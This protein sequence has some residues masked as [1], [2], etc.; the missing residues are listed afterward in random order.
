MD[1]EREVHR[2]R[3]EA[4]VDQPLG[5]V[6]R[7]EAVGEPVIREQGLVHARPRIPERRLECLVEAA[8][9]VVGVEHGILRHLPQPI[10]A[11]AE[12]VGQR[13][14]EHAHLAME[15]DHPAERAGVMLA[16]G[17][18]FD[19]V[20]AV[21]GLLDERQR[22]EGAERLREHHWPRTRPAAA[23][24][25]REGLVQVDVHRIDA[26]IARTHAPDDRVEIGAVA[27]DEPA[28]R[29]HRVR[30]HAHVALEQ[31]ASVGVGDHHAR[32][33]G[34]ES[35][36][37][38]LG[39]D[40]AV[41]G[42]GYVLDAIARERRG[43]RIG[44]V[45]ALGDEDDFP[46]PLATRFERRADREHAAQLAMRARLRAHRDRVHAG[47][48]D[49]PVRELLDHLERALHALHRR[50][51]VD[52]GETG[53]PRHLLVEARIVLHRARAEREEAEVD[54]VILA[55]QAGIVADGLGL[56]QTRK[57]DRRGTGE[58]AQPR[59]GG[60]GFDKVDAGGRRIADLEDQRFLQHQRL[61]AGG[62]GRSLTARD[63]RFG[64]PSACVDAHAS[65][66]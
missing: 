50:E 60:D 3:M 11:V 4:L 53:E 39:I 25:S 55:R 34:A 27:I 9:D 49:E 32:H 41:G 1:D 29:M 17:F 14:R 8:Q 58:V 44:A 48:R 13:A 51:R 20:E 43:R 23:M 18:L 7:R 28:R 47:E 21:V 45:R 24:R 65:T 37:Q 36:D 2:H 66:S 22:R 56:G 54:P 40:A 26:E 33:V 46:V 6:D 61:V 5:D 15:R 42:R 62:R 31:A 12:N 16:R 64:A 19:E 57:A 30:D 10:G 52:V 35:R 38:L 63:R 59:G